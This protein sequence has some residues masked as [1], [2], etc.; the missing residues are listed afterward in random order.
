MRCMGCHLTLGV[1]TTMLAC[2]IGVVHD[3][4]ACETQALRK[5]KQRREARRVML[6]RQQRGSS[7]AVDAPPHP[8]VAGIPQALSR[9]E[10]VLQ[11]R[12]GTAR[13]QTALECLAGQCEGEGPRMHC[14]SGCG[15]SVH[16]RCLGIAKAHA[17]LGQLRCAI[18][19]AEE[20]S[21]GTSPGPLLVRSAAKS[22]L[23]EVSL[24]SHSTAQGYSEYQRL[25]KEWVE[26]VGGVGCVLPRDSPESFVAFLVWLAAD[27]GR[28]R[29]FTTVWR[30]AA[31]VCARTR[32]E[33]MTKT[34]RVKRVY[35]DVAKS[36]GELGV[37]CTQTTRRLLQLTLGLEGACSTLHSGCTL[38]RGGAYIEAR[39]RVLMG[40]EVLGGLRVG[41]AVGDGHGLTAND[42]C[43]L[44]AC[45]GQHSELGVTVEARI[46]S[47]KTGPGRY[48]NCIGTSRVSKLPLEQY[49]RE[50]WTLQGTIMAPTEVDGGFS[51]ER[52]DFTVVRVELLGMPA[53]EQQRLIGL[54]MRESKL[55]EKSARGGGSLRGNAATSATYVRRRVKAE[56]IAEE[57]RFVNVAGGARLGSDVRKGREWLHGNGF[58]AW[59]STTAG[60]LLRATEAGS[61]RLTLMA[62]QVGST[63]THHVGA[64]RAAYEI[65][66]SMVDADVELE[67]QGQEVPHFANHSNRRFADRVARETRERS[68]ASVM[69]IDILFGWNEAQRHKDMQLHYAGLDRMQRVGRARVTMFI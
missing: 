32:T 39:S 26:S 47:S 41:E 65:S 57:R 19:R 36:L 15:R 21:G 54:L 7:G 12:V 31:G 27:S 35:E 34:A 8:V 13:V 58:G 6:E 23:W 37:P 16:S 68:G 14:S 43:L 69:D 62:M 28:A 60:P 50:L 53:R 38:S 44:K 40:L 67:L 45:T 10:V 5:E 22:M 66:S 9:R 42:V 59:E 55:G 3:T 18:C 46:R 33:S 25:E 52:P 56:D 64:L 63:Y 30:A 17:D 4:A 51:V 61:G 1:G 2:G 48:V 20:M 11:A 49:L 29:S 24:G